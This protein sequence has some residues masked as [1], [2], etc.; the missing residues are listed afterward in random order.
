MLKVEL[1]TEFVRVCVC[2]C[3]WLCLIVNENLKRKKE[4]IE[5][6][7]KKEKEN[8]IYKEESR[9]F[10]GYAG[11]NQKKK[12]R[13]RKSKYMKHQGPKLCLIFWMWTYYVLWA[14]PF[15]LFLFFPFLSLWS[16]GEKWGVSI[17]V[18]AWF[19]YIYTFIIP[20]KRKAYGHD[21][22]ILG[23]YFANI[24]NFTQAYNFPEC[25]E[26]L[27]LSQSVSFYP[28]PDHDILRSQQYLGSIL[29]IGRCPQFSSKSM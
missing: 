6:T 26:R 1:V 4:R 28:G 9:I 5:C 12:K 24:I 17:W 16:C 10:N 22:D 11:L 3:V 25:Q 20:F 27:F 2:V 13:E 19:C 14:L 8:R 23:L 18:P 15:V 29:M 7:E 21:H